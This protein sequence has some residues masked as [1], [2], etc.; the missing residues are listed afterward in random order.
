M[1]GWTSLGFP[2]PRPAQ[3]YQRAST[4]DNPEHQ[5]VLWWQV[6]VPGIDTNSGM[7][8]LSLACHVPANTADYGPTQGLLEGRAV[9]DPSLLEAPPGRSKTDAKCHVSP[10]TGK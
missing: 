9:P 6:N 10:G 1:R 2:S 4:G 3:L 7:G 8:S 5:P